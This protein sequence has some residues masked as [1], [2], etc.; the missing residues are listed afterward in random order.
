[1]KFFVNFKKLKINLNFFE[2][3]K[4]FVN[5]FVNIV[6]FFVQLK[7]KNFKNV[8]IKNRLKKHLNKINFKQRNDNFLLSAKL[9]L[10]NI[11]LSTILN[12]VKT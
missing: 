12:C 4:F 11:N 8:S 7:I 6:K 10:I 5:Y 1:M 3:Y 9:N 2:Y